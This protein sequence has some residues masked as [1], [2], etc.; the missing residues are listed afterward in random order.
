MAHGME[1]GVD[2]GSLRG[3]RARHRGR[4]C[5]CLRS[6]RHNRVAVVVAIYVIYGS[7]EAVSLLC[8]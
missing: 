4:R 3:V 5:C 7:F 1:R 8:R 6:G 2:G